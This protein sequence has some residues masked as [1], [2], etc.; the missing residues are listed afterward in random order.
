MIK[1]YILSRI[2]KTWNEKKYNLKKSVMGN[3]CIFFISD[4]SYIFSFSNT[5]FCIFSPSSWKSNRHVC[6]R[7]P[8]IQRHMN[9]WFW[10]KSWSANK[11]KQ[12]SRQ[13]RCLY[14]TIWKSCETFK[15]RRKWEIWKCNILFLERWS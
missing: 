5:L 12:S 14:T 11:N 3:C 9:P 15:E 7:S 10:W 2:K 1:I 4:N 8:R 13:I 6:Q